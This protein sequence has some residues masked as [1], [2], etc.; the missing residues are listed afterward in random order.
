MRLNGFFAPGRQ[1]RNDLLS[2]QVQD[3]RNQESNGR[4][5]LR[6]SCQGEERPSHWYP[7]DTL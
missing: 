2:K 7:L 6:V 1:C 5:L 4:V 3:G